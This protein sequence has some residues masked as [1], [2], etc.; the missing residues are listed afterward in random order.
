MIYV[1][2]LFYLS[3]VLFSFLFV[4]FH[5]GKIPYMLL[6]TVLLIPFV[7]LF[8]ILIVYYFLKYTKEF[9]KYNALKGNT[10]YFK[11]R[12]INKSLIFFPYLKIVFIGLNPAYPEY[13]FSQDLFLVPFSQKTFKFKYK[14]KYRGLYEMGIKAIE[15]RDFFGIFKLTRKIEDI[16]DIIIFPQIIHLDKF[17]VISENNIESNISKKNM[18]EDVSTISN[19]REYKI[20]DSLKKI[21]W[22]LTSKMQKFMIKDFNNSSDIN[23]V[24]LL[25]AKIIPYPHKDRIVIEDKVIECA[26]AIIYYFISKW[27]K[28]KLLYYCDKIN[29]IEMNSPAEFKQVYSL[30]AGLK[31]SGNTSIDKMV[32]LYSVMNIGQTSVIVLTSNISYDLYDIVYKAKKNGQDISIIYVSPESITETKNLDVENILT[33]LSDI[34]VSVYKININDNIKTVL[35]K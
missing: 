21:H 20:G 16:Q 3:L 5:G 25:D 34:D 12:L 11:S 31:F 35:E 30:L 18:F 14:C 9:N 22:K 27:I 1:N 28:V 8:H 2:R 15:I 6:Y 26:V 33:S 7:S 13:S 19:V 24:L 32:E 10:I 4:Y 17:D 23:C 29:E